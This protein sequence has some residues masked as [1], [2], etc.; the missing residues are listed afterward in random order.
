M[1]DKVEQWRDT[2][3][4]VVVVPVDVA[5]LC[6]WARPLTGLLFIPQMIYEVPSWSPQKKRKSFLII[7][8][9]WRLFWT[10]KCWLGTTVRTVLTMTSVVTAAN[11]SKYKWGEKCIKL[12]T[13]LKRCHEECSGSSDW[14][15]FIYIFSW[16]SWI[17]SVIKRNATN[18]L[19][20]ISLLCIKNR[21]PLE[22]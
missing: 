20:R 18:S 6:L 17:H 3:Q 10:N 12:A 14:K 21:K 7:L 9:L 8:K 11:Y 13:S 4:L 2:Y 19:S 1:A 15:T 22:H 5:R 16:E